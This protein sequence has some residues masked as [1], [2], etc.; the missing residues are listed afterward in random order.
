MYVYNCNVIER[1]KAMMLNS[2]VLLPIFVFSRIAVKNINFWLS[3]SNTAL[4]TGA[5]WCSSGIKF[6]QSTIKSFW[7]NKCLTFQPALVFN[8]QP[9]SWVVSTETVVV[10]FLVAS[11]IQKHPIR[12]YTVGIWK[13]SHTTYCWYIPVIW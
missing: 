7:V 8:L 13:H 10:S 12:L 4:P 6:D 11:E 3:L 9:S 5:A 2:L 1:Q